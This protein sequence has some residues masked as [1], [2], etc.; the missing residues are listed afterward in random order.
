MAA[1]YR[2]Y[3]YAATTTP[4]MK[5]RH[6]AV[7]GIVDAP[8]RAVYEV[9]ADYRNEHPK[10]VPKEYFTKLEVEE[11]GFGAG[12]RILGEMR[13]LGT[14]TAFRQVVSEPD[15]GRV[16]VE[17]HPDGS[18][19]TTFTMDPVEGGQKTALTISTD[20]VLQS[21]GLRALIEGSLIALLF[22]R[23]YRKEIELIRAHPSIRRALPR[24]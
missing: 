13:L 16:L 14:T 2:I 7:S 1:I 8:P 19:V 21:S 4:P 5:K 15:P 23:I 3:E 6:V 12:T 24:A 20:F 18:V 9:L 10:I 17:T 22:P 11:G